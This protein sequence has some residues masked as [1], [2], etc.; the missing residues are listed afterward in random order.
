MSEPHTQ[1]PL[2]IF[3]RPTL[4]VGKSFKVAL[5]EDVKNSKLSRDQVMDRMNDLADRNGVCLAHGNSKKLTMET[6]EKWLNPEDLTRMM[7]IKALPI[8]CAATGQCSAFTTM[9][10]PIGL[11]V[12]GAREQKMLAWAKAKMTIR[13]HNKMVRQIEGEL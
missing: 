7:P 5:A 9:T 11:K 13:E 2:D 10:H 8:F 3:N 6:L 1:L 4:N 12:I